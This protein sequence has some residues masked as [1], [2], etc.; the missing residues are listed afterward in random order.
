ML[1]GNLS[2]DSILGSGTA[3]IVELPFTEDHE[4]KP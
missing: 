2:V 4:N 1:G 3:L